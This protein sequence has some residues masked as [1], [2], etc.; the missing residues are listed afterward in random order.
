MGTIFEWFGYIALFIVLTFKI[1]LYL[2]VLW[3]FIKCFKAKKFKKC[4]NRKCKFHVYCFRYEDVLTEEMIEE[5]KK[6]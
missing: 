2:A 5:L 6:L 1:F 3:C 4:F